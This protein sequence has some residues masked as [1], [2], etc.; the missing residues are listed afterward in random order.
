MESTFAIQGSEEDISHWSL[1]QEGEGHVRGGGLGH[2][3]PT[4]IPKATNGQSQVGDG[5]VCVL[6]EGVLSGSH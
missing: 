4:K 3:S 1:R 6:V 2:T 5:A